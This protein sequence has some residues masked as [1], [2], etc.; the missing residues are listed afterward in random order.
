MER[1]FMSLMAL[2]H[3]FMKRFQRV[4]LLAAIIFIYY[5]SS[6]N[7]DPCD[8]LIFQIHNYFSSPCMS[9]LFIKTKSEFIEPRNCLQILLFEAFNHGDPCFEFKHCEGV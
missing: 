3:K 7:N 2:Y 4:K 5:I 1:E 9:H 6:Q 8:W